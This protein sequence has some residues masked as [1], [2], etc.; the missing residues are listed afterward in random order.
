[1]SKLESFIEA[2]KGKNPEL[3]SPGKCEINEPGQAKEYSPVQV[4]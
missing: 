1:M 4:Y 3:G 2:M